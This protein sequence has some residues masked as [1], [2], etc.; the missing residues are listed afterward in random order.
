MPDA[1]DFYSSSQRELQDEHDS[2]KLANAVVK[3]IVTDDVQ[4]EQA[5]FIQSRDFFFL[6]TVNASGEPTVSYKGGPVGVVQVPD[7]KTLVFP[8][9]DG[10]G[11][12]YSM[13]NARETGKVGLLF[14]DLETP[15]RLRVQ[16]KAQVTK[17]QDHLAAFPGALMIV[18]VAVQSVFIN[19]ARYIHKHTRVAQSPY[20]P[21]AEGRQPY[22]AWKRLE[23]IQGALPARD[24]GR[25][26]QHGGVISDDEY[27]SLL[28]RGES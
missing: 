6:A 1:N 9:Y 8:A 15:Q 27:Q 16:G 25:A 13:G 28:E 4:P 10:N 20:V 22:P 5:E 17:D 19:C 2:L 12:F 3:A 26:E 14:I 18:R 24:A 11:M 21:D 23:K 7:P